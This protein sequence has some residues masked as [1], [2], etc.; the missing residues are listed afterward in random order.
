MPSRLNVRGIGRR[1]QLRLPHSAT[2]AFI[3][4]LCILVVGHDLYRTWQDRSRRINE[5][6]REAANLVLAADQHAGDAFRIASTSLNE[7][8]ERLETD[9]TGPAQLERLRRL[10][11]QQV[12]SLPVL[13]S[14]DVMDD[15]GV[16]IAGSRS[17]TAGT[18]VSDREY[19]QYHRTHSDRELYVNPVIR[20]VTVGNLIVV[21]SRRINRADG[22]FAGLVVASIDMDYFQRFYATFNLGHD[23]LTGLYRDDAILLVRQPFLKSAVGQSSQRIALFRDWVPKAAQ[24]TFETISSLDGVTRIVSYRRVAGYPLVVYAALGKAEQLAVWRVG[25]AE[26][27]LAAVA[28]AM[29]LCA[30]GVRLVMQ[31]RL[32]TQAKLTEAA[33]T[34]AAETAAAQYRLLADNASDMIVRLDLQLIRRYVSPGCRDLLG[35]EP[36]EL[37][38]E[39]PLPFFHPEH[40]EH[41]T[42][43]LRDMAAGRDRNHITNRVRHRDG[44]WVWVDVSLKLMRDPESGAPMEI[45]VAMRDISERVA[46]L[47]ALERSE[48]S[49]RLLLESRAV[50]EAIYMLD[51]DGTIETW[52][53][54]AE[55]IKGYPAAE[56]IGRNFATFFTPE[57]VLSG[58]PARL[59]ARA[60][61]DG[62]LQTEG[63]RVRKD[64]SRFLANVMIDAIRNQDGS[65]RGFAK[66]TRDVTEQRVEEAQRAIIIE[67]APNG[68]MIVD[69]AGVI[70]LAN[71]QAERIFDYPRGAL[72]GEALEILVPEEFRMA[73]DVLRSAFTAGRTERGMA[74]DRQF[75]GRKRDGGAVTIEIMLSPVTTRRGRIVVASLV[76]VTERTRIAAER[77][78]I[79]TR[80]RL[81]VEATNARL[82]LL[83][84]HLTRARDRAEQAN[85]AKSRFLAGM[86]HELRTPLNGILGYAHLLQIEGG[87][88][89][90]QGARVEAMLEAGKHLLEMITCVLDL[91]EIEAE[92]VELHPIELDMRAIVAACLDL[93]RPMTAAK[94]LALSFAMAPGVAPDLVADPTRLRQILLNLLGN[95][96]KFT[97]QGGVA[98][99]LARSMGGSRLRIE[100]ADTGPG[101]ASEERQRLFQDFERVGTETTNTSEGA[102]LG[103]ALSARLAKVMGGSLGYDDNPGGGSIFWLELPLNAVAASPP[104]TA[105]RSDATD[106]AAVPAPARRL[107]VLVVDDVLMNRDVASSFLRAAGHTAVC[108]EGGAE[109]VAAVA[110]ADFDVVL[111]DVRMPGVDGLEATRRIRALEGARGQV[112]IVALTAQAFTDQVAACHAAGMDGHLPKPFDPGTL[113]AAVE[114]AVFTGRT[115]SGGVPVRPANTVQAGPAIAAIGSE[116]PVIDRA[117][118]DRTA[119]FLPPESVDPHVQSIAERADDL[120]RQLRAWD[121]VV[122]PGDG[123]VDAVH[124]LAG[125]AGMFGFERLSV[126]GRQLERAVHSGSAETQA[127]AD[128]L[129]AALE[130]TVQAINDFSPVAV[131][132]QYPPRRLFARSSDTASG[133]ATR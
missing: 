76:D 114:R 13:Q 71:S 107:H 52:N 128:G 130:A 29:L 120:L 47:N 92:H 61:A 124:S 63:W 23:G 45:C 81:A 111:M 97:G 121:A 43:C 85:R 60:V 64:G 53:A 112:P 30:I 57:D 34:A 94:G 10:M 77:K 8:V 9:G 109:A 12:A 133:Q 58:E 68:M 24:G 21:I 103:L 25:A 113:I 110:G 55:R 70:T 129:A 7:L 54:A 46:A 115:N 87:L 62:S 67:A 50:T 106:T 1:G 126:V 65:L 75:T 83:S 38:G 104:A 59:L 2:I 15:S 91:S 11:T 122:R 69:E 74:P 98:V 26:H 89:R 41:V 131:G 108:A 80:E 37:E 119:A 22:G 56:I 51:P 132:S 118:F 127:L 66:V 40:S 20:S 100:V 116:L 3:A 117:A 73:H 125:S 102:G 86:S 105:L 19:F 90:A 5:S 16:I 32:L 96:V 18:N 82:E 72:V 42:A 78:E 49:F 14:L 79:E 33:A 48:E 123:L 36:E 27:L 4:I 95:A 39:S 88:T 35:Y 31:V 93:V 44:H 17:V 6:E 99:R 84:R 101:I 28:V